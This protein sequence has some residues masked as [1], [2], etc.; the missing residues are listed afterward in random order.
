M[1]DQIINFNFRLLHYRYRLVKEWNFPNVVFPH[2]H[3]YWTGD[4]RGGSIHCD[5][6]TWQLGREN[7]ILI[8]PGALIE[9]RNRRPFMQ[10]YFHFN[11]NIPFA[12]VPPGVYT[13]KNDPC[14]MELIHKTCSLAANDNASKPL[15]P[16][17]LGA[18]IY[19][20]VMQL[21]LDTFVQKP[22]LA[23]KIKQTADYLRKNYI[24]HVSNA[25]LAE[26]V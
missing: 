12:I 21:P 20:A 8:A 11:L 14:M 5:G 19:H 18:L 2:W 26:K 7:L 13:V 25:D 15:L 9:S 10:L 23:P 22:T 3:C 6:N 16:L 4:R 1:R 17:E 24:Q